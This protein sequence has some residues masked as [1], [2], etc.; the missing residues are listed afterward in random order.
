MIKKE[1]FQPVESKCFK[2]Q[3]ENR[4]VEVY[5]N[6]FGNCQIFSIAWFN[7]LVAH[8]P[9]DE[10]KEQLNEIAS[11]CGYKPILQLDINCDLK[12]AVEE[13][14]PPDRIIGKIDYASTNGSN[15]IQY[16]IKYP[17]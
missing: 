3:F 17:Y 8:T 7:Y 5:A 15:M 1:E 6:P 13:I 12:F 9:K 10:I 2:L 11:A 14:F 16:L 4:Y